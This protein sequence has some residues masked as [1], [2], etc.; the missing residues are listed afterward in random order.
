MALGNETVRYKD[1][2]W[3][4]ICDRTGFKIRASESRREWNGLIVHQSVWEPR[5][6]QD[7]VRGTRDVQT[8]PFVRSE[9]SDDF[10]TDNEVTVSSL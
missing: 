5:H 10:L 6:P 1:G 8:P 2:D 3:Y 4:V 9:A 7:F